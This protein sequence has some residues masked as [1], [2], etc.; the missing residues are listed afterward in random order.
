[1]GKRERRRRR[2]RAATDVAPPVAPA[3]GVEDLRELWVVAIT[4]IEQLPRRSIGYVQPVWDGQPSRMHWEL[5]GKP[6]VNRRSVVT[7][8]RAQPATSV[9]TKIERRNG[10]YCSR[11]GV[12]EP[13]RSRMR[14]WVWK[15]ST[16]SW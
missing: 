14:H 11:T 8:S 9:P 2:E 10:T 4:W 13:A 3:A 5:V 15:P 1:M 6:H 12:A 16:V 7:R